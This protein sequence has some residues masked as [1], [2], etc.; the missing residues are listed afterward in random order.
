MALFVFID[1]GQLGNF[2]VEKISVVWIEPKELLNPTVTPFEDMRQYY[3]Q[4]II[5]LLQF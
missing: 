4:Y 3:E 1:S 2:T 5:P